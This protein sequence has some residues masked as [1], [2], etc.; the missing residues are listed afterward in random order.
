MKIE[1]TGSTI[2]GNTMI[3][4]RSS[5]YETSNS[6]NEVKIDKSNIN[7]NFSVLEDSEISF[8]MT[9]LE[10]FLENINI[11]TEEYNDL[12]LLLTENKNKKDILSHI[13]SHLINFSGGVLAS[14]IANYFS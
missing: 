11:N 8:I 4:N 3:G 2:R 14:I 12:K 5:F 13:K 10:R 1:I 6:Q 7:G 9:D